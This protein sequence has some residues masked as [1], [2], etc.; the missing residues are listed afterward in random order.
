[1]KF[2]PR[3][4]PPARCLHSV[5]LLIAA[6]CAYGTGA[7]AQD[8]AD[9]GLIGHWTFNEFA[10]QRTPD[11]S[12]YGNHA[13]VNN[14]T[15]VNGVDGAGLSFGPEPGWVSCPDVPN[16][17]EALSIEAWYKPVV[18]HPEAF[19]AIVRKEGAYALRFAERGR[20]GFLVWIGG[21][22]RYLHSSSGDWTV[23]Q[24]HHIAATYDGSRMRLF[25]NG[26]ED[27]AS[28]VAL[29][30]AISD[31][32][33][34]CGIGSCRGRYP[35][36]GIVD[37]VKIYNRPLVA[38][39]IATAHQAGLRTLAAQRDVKV[40]P[41]QIGGP[42]PPFRKP[43]REV[44]MVVPG[45][46]WIDAEDFVDYGGWT[47]DTQFV[48]LMGSGYLLA[49]GVGTPVEDATT[50]IDV[51]AAGSFRVWVRARNWVREQAPGRFQLVLNGRVLDKV[52]G[53]A[54][55]ADWLWESAGDIDL[56]AGKATLVLRD[57]TGYYGRCDALVLTT[58]KGYEPP[59]D[60]AGVCRER[61]RLTGLSLEPAFAGQFDVIVVGAGSAGSPAAL[62]AARTGAKTA[63]I[64]NRPVLGGNSSR[65]CGVP[66]NGAA[67]H[68]PNSRET[69]IAEEVHRTKA[70]YGSRAY[71]EPF[72][73]LADAEPN[74]TVFVNRHVFDVEM[75]DAQHIA[76]V[77]A[78]DTLSGAITVYRGK[79]FI[80]CT[81]DGWVGYFAK[82]EYRLGREARSE[83][84]ESNAPETAD[85]ITM[86]G[87]LMGNALGYR[88]RNVGEPAAFTRPPWAYDIPTLDGYGRRVRHITGGEWWM[89]HPGDVDDL[90]H[91]EEARDELIRIVFGYW[92]YIKNKSRLKEEAETYAIVHVPHMDAKRESRRLIGDY[93]LTQ[94]DCVDGRVFPDRISY[95]GW[96]LDIHHPRGIFSGSEGSFDYNTHVPIYTIPYRCVY[97]KNI[98]N[99]LFA[100]R[101]ASVS[102]VALGTIRVQSTLATLGQAA[103]TAAALC[104]KLDTTPRGIYEQHITML[105]QK[106]LKDDQTIPELVNDDP[107][108]LARTA[109]VRA[110]TTA[111]YRQFTAANVRSDSTIHELDHDRVMIFPA[112]KG[113]LK[114]IS[115]RVASA[116]AEPTLLTLH[117]REAQDEQ[118]LSSAADVATATAMVAPNQ[119]AWVEFD[120]DVE[121][122]SSY[123]WFWLPRTE[124]LSWRLMSGATKGCARGY[125]SGAANTWTL[126]QGEFYAFFTDPCLQTPTTFR[127]QNVIDGKA[128][129]WDGETNMWASDPSQPFPQWIELDFGKPTAVN[130]VYLTFDT[131]M[132][133][134]I[135]TA[136]RPPECVRDYTVSCHDGAGW[137]TVADVKGNWQR[138]RIHR[139]DTANAGKVRL[140]ITATNGD[141]SGRVFE[142]RAYCE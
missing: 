60:R 2:R 109:T 25:I 89:E 80:D 16:V 115:V 24:W 57:L 33:S 96:P 63:L 127:V 76:A 73:L 34:L 123:L 66:L 5:F 116:N 15:R 35:L 36:Q 41:E 48:H 137:R 103:G 75:R 136:A 28:P 11:A 27:E 94:N 125:G 65:E 17:T 43:A 113:K 142:M 4:T 121:V 10:E 112:V 22:P 83:H 8:S 92:D 13:Q 128:R 30:G 71:S 133:P 79:E 140:T 40:E 45:F 56:P 98:E 49:T 106:L 124:G 108:D 1:M 53:A 107:L 99:L 32:G 91:A 14:V 42:P 61:A 74:L 111:T 29:E 70:Y 58:D 64:Q 21:V 37:E 138:R 81:G 130:A 51:P 69:G 6:A 39:E 38:D 131:N 44:K 126:R 55:S 59:S 52:F 135:P 77:K 110:S 62:A 134:R 50:T 100:G 18:A 20:L 105:Q 141:Q 87:C 82:A 86:S 119:E 95:G 26:V 9:R 129:M 118:D 54:D 46:L 78:V 104:V 102:H 120:L 88:A 72:K 3:Y 97:S 31:G 67:S 12:S 68:H 114:Q 19:A 93:V 84:D 23:G 132:A 90:W 101:C 139:F 122:T 117:L 47:L 7:L 85:T